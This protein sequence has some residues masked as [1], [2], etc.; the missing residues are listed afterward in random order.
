MSVTE[1]EMQEF[2]R[3]VLR[4]VKENADWGVEHAIEALQQ[5]TGVSR[6]KARRAVVAV[7]REIARQVLAA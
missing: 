3:A 1:V 6:V 7:Y 2:D 5:S 4:A